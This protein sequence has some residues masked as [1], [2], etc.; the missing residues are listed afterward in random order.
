MLDFGQYDLYVETKYREDKLN[1]E[2]KTYCK[3][4]CLNLEYF[5][6]LLALV[7]SK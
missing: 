2:L 3:N 1:S 4:E 5:K 6:Y 7:K